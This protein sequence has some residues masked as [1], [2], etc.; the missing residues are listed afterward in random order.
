MTP[1]QQIEE[2]RANCDAL[3][4]S[5][6]DANSRVGTLIAANRRAAKVIAELQVQLA[7]KTN[8]GEDKHD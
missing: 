6:A 4:M 1:E 3:T 2:L 8:K 5:L 7:E